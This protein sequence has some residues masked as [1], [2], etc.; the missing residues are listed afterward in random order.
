MR[1]VYYSFVSDKTI[2]QTEIV[3]NENNC[4]SKYLKINDK[5]THYISYHM[6]KFFAGPLHTK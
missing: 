4:W 3:E 6:K 2:E 5:N 1:H